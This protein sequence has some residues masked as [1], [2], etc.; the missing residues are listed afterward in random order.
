VVLE[1]YETV[2][3]TDI[4]DEHLTAITAGEVHGLAFFAIQAGNLVWV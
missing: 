4:D 2:P 1:F 3:F